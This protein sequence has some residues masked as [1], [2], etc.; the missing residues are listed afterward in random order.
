[1]LNRIIFLTLCVCLVAGNCAAQ[2]TSSKELLKFPFT[3]RV[4]SDRV[5]IRA[6]QSNNYESIIMVEKGSDLVVLGKLYSWYKVALP[7]GAKLFLKKEHAKP[8]S[9]EV[10]EVVVDRVNVRARPNT[11]AAIIGQLVRGEQFFIKGVSGDKSDWFVIRPVAKTVGWVHEDFIEFKN[12]TVPA[13]LYADPAEVAVRAKADQDASELKHSAKLALLKAVAPGQYEA[14][15]ILVPIVNLGS[16]SYKLMGGAKGDVCVAY[17][18]G[19]SSVL[20][21][22]V[23]ARVIVRGAVKDEASLNA[24]VVTVGKISLAL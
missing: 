1:M 15:G 14:Q 18:S 10:G 11:D 2:G 5:N 8:L 17:V 21:S 12:S 7:E 22:F 19:A 16:V 13:K 4:V 6:G 24:A 3:A 20:E 9:T 23:G